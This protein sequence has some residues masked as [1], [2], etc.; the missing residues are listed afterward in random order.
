MESGSHIP[1]VGG[2][3]SSEREEVEFQRIKVGR[4]G[5]GVEVWMKNIETNMLTVVQRR[6]KEAHA[7]YYAER[8]QRKDWVLAHIGQAVA[9][10][11]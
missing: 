10:I 1:D 9:A 4:Q 5:T 3:I 8:V 7:N 2:M 6:I 11:A